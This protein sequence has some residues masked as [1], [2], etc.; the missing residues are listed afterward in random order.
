MAF[1]SAFFFLCVCFFFT[2][3]TLDTKIQ[4]TPSSFPT[5][6]FLTRAAEPDPLVTVGVTALPLQSTAQEMPLPQRG[7]IRKPAQEVTCFGSASHR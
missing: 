6:D 1:L 4:Q 2:P 5:P 7:K 3:D